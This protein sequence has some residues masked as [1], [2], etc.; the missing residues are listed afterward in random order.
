MSTVRTI[1]TWVKVNLK[2]S[3]AA[4]LSEKNGICHFFATRTFAF[5]ETRIVRRGIYSFF[6]TRSLALRLLGFS[7]TSSSLGIIG[8]FVY[9]ANEDF[10]CICPVIGSIV[11]SRYQA[12]NCFTRR[13]SSEWNV[14]TRIIHPELSKE[15][16]WESEFSI[17]ANSS[18]TNIRKAWKTRREDFWSKLDDRIISRSLKVVSISSSFLLLTISDAINQDFFS[19]PYWVNIFARSGASKVI[20]T[21]LAVF[22]WERSKRISSGQSKRREKPL[23]PSSRWTLLTQR[24]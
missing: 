18:F 16:A 3:R 9:F 11:S 19:S 22:P 13:S 12:K 4:F 24:S 2:F 5:I 6:I 10:F 7:D 14:I 15:R 23:S 1:Y 8:F 17:W 21:S 20:I